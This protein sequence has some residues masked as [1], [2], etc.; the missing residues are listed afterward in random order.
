MEKIRYFQI[1]NWKDVEIV[2][3]DCAGRWLADH[4]RLHPQAITKEQY[5]IFMSGYWRGVNDTE[6]KG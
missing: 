5:D 3:A 1:N 4:Q 2:S 6:Q